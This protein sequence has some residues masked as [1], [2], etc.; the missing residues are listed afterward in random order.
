MTSVIICEHQIS[1]N[2]KKDAQHIRVINE[3]TIASF[4]RELSLQS[5]ND[6]LNINDVNKA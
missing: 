6:I 5:W 3:D 2:A 1:R 4:S